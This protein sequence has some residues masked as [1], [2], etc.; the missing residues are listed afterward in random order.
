CDP[1]PPHH[2]QRRVVIR[3][4]LGRRD[5]ARGACQRGRAVNATGEIIPSASAVTAAEAR[6]SN[7][8]WSTLSDEINQYGCAPIPTLLSSEECERIAELYSHEERFR[9]HIHMARHGF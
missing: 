7:Y 3:I 2:P 9:S 6:I 5:Q 4:S 8:D 1:L